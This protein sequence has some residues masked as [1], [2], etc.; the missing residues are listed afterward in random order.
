MARRMAIF[1]ERGVGS[2]ISDEAVVEDVPG[3]R[4][5]DARGLVEGD[6]WGM[7]VWTKK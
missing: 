1:I 7:L 2:E 3:W 5:P 6:N 4:E